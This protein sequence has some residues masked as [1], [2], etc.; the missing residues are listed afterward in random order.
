MVAQLVG[1]GLAR[2][3]SDLYRLKLEEISALERRGEKSAAN[4]LEA[5]HASRQRDLPRLL[6]GL[7][8]LH[9]GINVAKL[10][11]RAFPDLDAIAKA[12]VAELLAIEGIGETI[13]RSIEQW[14]A[15][16]L[17]RGLVSRLRSHG[18]NFQSSIHRPS[19][20][21]SPATAFAG[22]TVVLTGTLPTLSREQAT[23]L[24]ERHGGKVSS[25]VSKKTHYVLAGD[26]A[27]SKLTKA[28]ELG[29][30]VLTEAEFLTRIG[31]D[32]QSG[33]RFDGTRLA[34]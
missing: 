15:D 1:A 23:A 14:F 2:D 24:I 9:V 34:P 6:F 3:P 20:Q 18:L 17:N 22:C 16:P 27:G 10:L 32:T 19:E 4:F 28:Q 7:G 13:G 21:I 30:T 12:S 26:E 29:I 11:A 31:S 33:N 5:I 25:S 8:I